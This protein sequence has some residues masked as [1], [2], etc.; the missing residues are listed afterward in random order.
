MEWTRPASIRAGLLVLTV[1]RGFLVLGAAMW[2]WAVSHIA[3]ALDLERHGIRV[4]ATVLADGR[5]PENPAEQL[6]LPLPDGTTAIEWTSAVTSQQA[7]GSPLAVVYL[8][9]R[10]STVESAKYLRWWWIAAVLPPFGT[11]F[12]LVGLLILRAF[13]RTLRQG[14]A[15]NNHAA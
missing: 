11:A 13:V 4:S 15:D 9:C 12:F 1:F 8:P 2:I 10:P 6:S 14:P 3:H 5:D 7:P